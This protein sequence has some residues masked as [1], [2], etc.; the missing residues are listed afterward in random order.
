MIKFADLFYLDNV[1]VFLE[2]YCCKYKH[3]YNII[4]CCMKY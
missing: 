3:V 2:Q 4:G 1:E